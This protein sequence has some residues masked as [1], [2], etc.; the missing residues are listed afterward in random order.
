VSA[1]IQGV[2]GSTVSEGNQPVRKK[3]HPAPVVEEIFFFMVATR[4]SRLRYVRTRC[5]IVYGTGFHVGV[6]NV[7][8][9]ASSAP[10][11]LEKI[12]PSKF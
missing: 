3:K 10:E 11:P 8:V 5:V 2:T 7:T 1:S 12:E 6:K 4:L 9:N